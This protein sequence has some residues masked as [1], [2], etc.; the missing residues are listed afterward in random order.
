MF[1]NFFA[2]GIKKVAGFFLKIG[3]MDIGKDPN[4]LNNINS[5]KSNTSEETSLIKNYNSNY[6]NE[7]NLDR[8]IYLWHENQTKKEDLDL[9]SYKNKMM[10]NSYNHIISNFRHGIK[11][12]AID[13]KD[14]EK[15][16]ENNLFDE[17]LISNSLKNRVCEVIITANSPREDRSNA[18]QL[19]H[20]DG[21]FLSVLDG[22]G[23]DEVADFASK[24]LHKKFENKL[25]ELKEEMINEQDK[26]KTAIKYAFEQIV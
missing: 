20:Y 22:H 17:K 3:P 12:L 5:N 19:K 14:S 7:S 16:I 4:I 15:K 1:S 11:K 26:V 8:N 25:I 2:K 24:E 13:E 18:I 21:Y 10:P 9:E 6:S 23:G